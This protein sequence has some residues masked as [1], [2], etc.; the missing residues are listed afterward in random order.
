MIKYEIKLIDETN[1]KVP[2]KYPELIQVEALFRIVIDEMVFFEEPNFPIYEFLYAARK[3]IKQGNETFEYV[4][5]ETE[6]NP[7]ISFL[8][9]GEGWIIKSPWQL[10]ECKL[11]FTREE[12]VN[13]IISIDI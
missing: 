1:K 2:K 12:L 13:A 8:Y 4:S 5:V 3:W 10:F 6:E 9:E 11:K 7:L